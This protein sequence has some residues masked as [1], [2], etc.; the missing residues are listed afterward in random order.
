[1]LDQAVVWPRFPRDSREKRREESKFGRRAGP[2]IRNFCPFCKIALYCFRLL[3]IAH[4]FID[5]LPN[6]ARH[7]IATIKKKNNSMP[8]WKN[9]FCLYSQNHSQIDQIECYDCIS[10]K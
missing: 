1:M 6:F 4:D 2:S 7:L 9:R 5:A 8:W 3:V 10:E